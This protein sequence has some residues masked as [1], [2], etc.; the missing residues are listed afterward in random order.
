MQP[1]F[2]KEEDRELEGH[3]HPGKCVPILFPASL[4]CQSL[5]CPPGLNAVGKSYCFQVHTHLLE[6]HIP[7]EQSIVF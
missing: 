5:T 1:G 4:L 6:I 2:R 7:L 3:C